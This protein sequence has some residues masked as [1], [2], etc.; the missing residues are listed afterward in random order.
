[1][2]KILGRITI[3][4]KQILEVDADPTTDSGAQ[5]A[6]SDVLL[7][8]LALYGTSLYIKSGA[9]G[10]GWELIPLDSGAAGRI[11]VSQAAHGFV[12]GEALYLNGA[13]YAKAK[14][15]AASTSEVVGVVSAVVD[16]STFRLTTYGTISGLSGLVAGS[17]YFLSSSVAGQL[18][19]TEPTVIGQVSVPVLVATSATAGIINIMRGAVIGGA[20]VRTSIALANNA[21]TTIQSL[22][23]Y[24]AAELT[25][26]ISIV[27]TTPRKF[28]VQAQVA[29]NGTNTDYNISY[30]TTGDTQPTGFSMAVTSAGLVQVV[31]PS[32]AGFT[33]ASINYALNAPAVGTTFPLSVDTANLVN[34]NRIQTK[35]ATTNYTTSTA[36]IIVFNGLT[37][38]KTYRL[39]MK[40]TGKKGT[41]GAGNRARLRAYHN[42]VEINYC[43]YEANDGVIANDF[44]AGLSSM[45]VFVAAATTVS[46]DA[47]VNGTGSVI[48]GSTSTTRPDGSMA[49]LEELNIADLTTAFT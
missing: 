28:Y 36:A 32:L 11:T 48:S 8:S 27:A 44:F 38:G 9:A 24:E 2:L 7:G 20:N 49:I 25:G 42:S 26:W 40:A 47:D 45:N 18:T 23:A 37:I 43:G 19:L 46:I 13:T 22:S 6:L 4:D 29:K 17:N 21:T 1:M 14:A 10:T 34:K 5:A 41:S 12:V 15:D 3:N 35:I 33:S 31:M 30:Q 16:A 39:V